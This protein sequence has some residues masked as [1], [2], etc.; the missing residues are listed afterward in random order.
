MRCSSARPISRL[1]GLP[2]GTTEPR[3]IDAFS[4]SARSGDPPGAASASMRIDERL[5]AYAA[6]GYRLFTFGSDLRLSQRR[7][8]RDGEFARGVGRRPGQ[9]SVASGKHTKRVLSTA[10]RYGIHKSL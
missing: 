9:D 2:V 4:T 1:L 5:E 8:A 6:M 3:M 10:S 7:R